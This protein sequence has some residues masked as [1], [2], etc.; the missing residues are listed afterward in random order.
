MGYSTQYDKGTSRSRSSSVNNR[1]ISLTRTAGDKIFGE[2]TPNIRAPKFQFHTKKRNEEKQNITLENN[3]LGHRI[4][5]TKSAIPKTAKL[6]NQNNQ[7]NKYLKMITRYKPGRDKNNFVIMN[8]IESDHGN[9]NVKPSYKNKF[10]NTCYVNS[11]MNGLALLKGS[12]K[13]DN[14]RDIPS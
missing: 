5:N 4:I 9:Y 7:S 3:R 12:M 10:S 11:Q 6:L 1:R 8:A 13:K 14:N 2:S